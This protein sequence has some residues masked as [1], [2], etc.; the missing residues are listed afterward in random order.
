MLLEILD[1]A[2][3][4]LDFVLLTRNYNAPG[5]LLGHEC[6]GD[7]SGDRIRRAR[8]QKSLTIT[9]LAEMVD[10]SP[11]A[12]IYIE[13]GKTPSLSTLRKLSKVLET[14]IAYLGCFE[15]M[16]DNTFGQ[17]IKKARYYHG[18]MVKEM[19]KKLGVNSKSIIAWEKNKYRP[20]TANKKAIDKL[21]RSL[22][23]VD[24]FDNFTSS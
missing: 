16:P 10:M 3:N 22:E 12:I 5:W 11:A 8:V 7:G 13:S 9:E 14:P 21:V 4:I 24:L 17:K 2:G 18:L 1:R 15:K 6:S 23:D 20:S 19:A